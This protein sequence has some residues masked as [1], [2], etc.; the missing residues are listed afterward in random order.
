MESQSYTSSFAVIYDDVM[1]RVP[2]YY[3]YKYLKHLLAYYDK[4]PEKIMELACGTGNMI[5]YFAKEAD[6]IY[7][8]DK[9]KDM[10]TVAQNKFSEN[11]NVELFNTDMS[12]KYKYGEFDLIYSIFDS[13]NYILE[14]EDLLRVFANAHYN[15]NQDGIFIFDMNTIYRLMDISEG[16]NKIEG[17][18][19]TCYWRD[20]VDR[21]KKEWIV[22][23]NI[24]LDR[25]ENIENFTE[26]HVET[27]YSL[28]KI[29]EALLEAGFKHVDYYKSFTFRSGKPQNNRI[30]F[31]AMKKKPE[32]KSI[33][34]FLIKLKWNLISPFISSF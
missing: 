10:L 3:W 17:D 15:L 18:D 30:H 27:S 12:E 19:Y 31:A 1:Q 9:S 4:K 7:G 25:G 11:D 13:L 29:K 5:K 8:I 33:K 23:L 26:K 14:Y 2:Y 34:N 16:T 6:S 32:S 24:Y 21:E 20:I 28:K 22:E